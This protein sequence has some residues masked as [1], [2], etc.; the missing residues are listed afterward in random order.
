M[1][2]I[3]KA[4]SPLR[5]SGHSSH[6]GDGPIIDHFRYGRFKQMGLLAPLTAGY[7][8]ILD[9]YGSL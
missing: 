5:A 7:E 2:T 4:K 8:F 6:V 1:T 9:L 3:A